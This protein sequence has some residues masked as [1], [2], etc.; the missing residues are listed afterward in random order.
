MAFQE[1][2]FRPGIITGAITSSVGAL[3]I[4]QLMP[5]FFQSVNVPKPFTAADT[6]AQINESATFLASLWRRFGDWQ[7]AVAGYNWGGGDVHHEYVVD[8]NRYV[9]ADMPPQ[10]QSYVRNVFTDVPIQGVLFP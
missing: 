3:G 9:L 10:T 1:S 4:L 5:Q 7:V 8:H 2:S 6:Q